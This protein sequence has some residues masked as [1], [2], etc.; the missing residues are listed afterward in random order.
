MSPTGP[1]KPSERFDARLERPTSGE[2]LRDQIV[3]LER[4][5]ILS[6]L[7]SIGQDPA[8]LAAAVT[9]VGARRR[10]IVGVG[11]SHL[12]AQLFAHSLRASLRGVAVL[13][14]DFEESV[15]V[16]SEVGTDDAVVAFS[17]RRYRAHTIQVAELAHRSGATV[18]AITDS[19]DSPISQF[20]QTV[21]V[22]PTGSGSH[23]DSPTGITVVGHILATLATARAKGA[24][25][26]LGSREILENELLD[27]TFRGEPEAF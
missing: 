19:A 10:T 11:R 18:V 7:E 21:I 4:A 20:A 17:F 2:M 24:R 15:N 22:V 14:T 1:E 26:R 5:N 13:G 6:A 27:Y 3:S 16:L 12:H 23:L 8:V 25:R 9:I